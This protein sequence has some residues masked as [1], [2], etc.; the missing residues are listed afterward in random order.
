MRANIS[1]VAPPSRLAGDRSKVQR[2]KRKGPQITRMGRRPAGNTVALLHQSDMDRG[3]VGSSLRHSRYLRPFAFFA[4]SLSCFRRG[5]HT[6]AWVGTRAAAPLSAMTS[7]GAG[8]AYV[9]AYGV[10][11][12]ARCGRAGPP[13]RAAAPPA[14]CGAPGGGP[15]PAPGPGRP[16]SATRR[17]M[18][19]PCSTHRAAAAIGLVDL[20]QTGQCA[21]RP[22]QIDAAEKCVEPDEGPADRLGPILARRG[23]HLAHIRGERKARLLSG[24]LNHDTHPA[25]RGSSVSARGAW[26][27][28]AAAR[29]DA[30]RRGWQRPDR[31]C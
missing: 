9:S 15:M 3:A 16:A 14:R 8:G 7:R 4:L 11:P 25:A 30:P 29:G 26:A 20:K 18:R 24:P 28:A 13:G 22:T 31:Q 27:V 6:A 12:G 19:R 17:A 21:E 5:R 2:E 1:P 23:E 10:N